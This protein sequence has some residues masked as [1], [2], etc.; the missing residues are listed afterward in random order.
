MKW[1]VFFLMSNFK[2]GGCGVWRPGGVRG[3]VER[4]GELPQ[5]EPNHTGTTEPQR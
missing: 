2:G 1:S 5:L 3:G 4:R